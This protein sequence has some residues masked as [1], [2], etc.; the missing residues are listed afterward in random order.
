MQNGKREDGRIF[1]MCSYNWKYTFAACCSP[2]CK[3]ARGRMGGFFLLL[4]F[5][6]NTILQ[7]VA[8]LH[9]K[10][11]V[12]GWEDFVLMCACDINYILQHFANFKQ[13]DYFWGWPTWP[14]A[15]EPQVGPHR[16]GQWG[17]ALMQ[18]RVTQ[19]WKKREV[20]G[21]V[22]NRTTIPTLMNDVQWEVGRK[23]LLSA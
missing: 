4:S 3:V 12:G 21:V 15:M 14:A 19:N 18:D 11:Q 22:D 16:V 10:W 2:S 8:Q 23:N 13:N 7:H 17:K 9:A 5:D 1:L 6:I 20:G